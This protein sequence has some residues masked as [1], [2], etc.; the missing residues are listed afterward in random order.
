[1]AEGTFSPVKK[2]KPVDRKKDM[3][4]TDIQTPNLSGSRRSFLKS[5]GLLAFSA[6]AAMAVPFLSVSGAP[7]WCRAQF[8]AEGVIPMIPVVPPIP[9]V[10]PPLDANPM[11]PDIDPLPLPEGFEVR[12]RTTFPVRDRNILAVQLFTVPVGTPLPLPEAL[13]PILPDPN[14][15][16][17]YYEIRVAWIEIGCRPQPTIGLTGRVVLHNPQFPFYGDQTGA[18]AVVSGGFVPGARG[19][20]FTMLMANVAGSHITVAPQAAGKLVL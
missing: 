16:M 5:A 11:T 7:Q 10:L 17:A 13:P 9:W 6:P 12:L 19:A 1:V 18:T 20:T 4:R 2:L 14:P 15:T 8:V 3:K